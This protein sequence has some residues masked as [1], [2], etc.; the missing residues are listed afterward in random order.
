MKLLKV[1][2]L[3]STYSFYFRLKYVYYNDFPS[4]VW[5]PGPKM[6]ES[7]YWHAC[8]SFTNYGN[9]ILVVTPGLNGTGVE[10][11]DLSQENPEWIN[12]PPLPNNF[13]NCD[14]CYNGQQIVSNGDTLFYI[15]TNG[16][17]PGILRLDCPSTDLTY[18]TWILLD[19]KPQYQR[20]CP[21]TSLIPDELADC[22]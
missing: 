19:Q 22:S 4:N 9:T 13:L 21:I 8:G 5:T 2:I 11:L 17:V 14:N 6:I 20:S 7:R 10:L 1:D 3:H 18:C 15:N 16:E 12:G